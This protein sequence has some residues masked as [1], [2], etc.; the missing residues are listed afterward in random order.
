LPPLY[1]A[2]CENDKDIVEL[3][4]RAGADVRARDAEGHTPLD[5][6]AQAGHRE[7]GQRRD[8]KGLLPPAS[9]PSGRPYVREVC[10]R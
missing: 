7:L 6:A 2:I 5:W 1:Y 8:P 9:L 10:R 3:L 4:V